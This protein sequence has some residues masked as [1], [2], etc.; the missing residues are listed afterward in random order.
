MLQG[1]T[2]AALGA[3]GGAPNPGVHAGEVSRAGSGAK[4]S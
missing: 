1:K 4:G 3:P 2:E